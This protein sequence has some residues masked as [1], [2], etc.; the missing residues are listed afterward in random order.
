MI[1]K[2]GCGLARKGH[3]NAVIM[4]SQWLLRIVTHWCRHYKLKHGH[5]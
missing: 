3:G 5:F 4:A 2:Q 1:N